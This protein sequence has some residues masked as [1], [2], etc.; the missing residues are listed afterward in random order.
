MTGLSD[1]FLKSSGTDLLVKNAHIFAVKGGASD[2]AEKFALDPVDINRPANVIRL[3]TTLERLFDA[4]WI[5]ILWIEARQR[6][7]MSTATW[8]DV[9]RFLNA[10]ALPGCTTAPELRDHIPPGV[11]W[12]SLPA[13]NRKVNVDPRAHV[14]YQDLD[15]WPLQPPNDRKCILSQRVVA[16][17]ATIHLSYACKGRHGAD[18]EQK[19]LALVQD[20]FRC[21]SPNTD[22]VQARHRSLCEQWLHA[23]G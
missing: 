21:R 19:S 23:S 7:E 6:Y 20:A 17:M 8:P 11:T 2:F 4:G 16:F 13:I 14:L 10:S 9:G 22:A 5:T 12:G 3:H 18:A 15:G 1:A